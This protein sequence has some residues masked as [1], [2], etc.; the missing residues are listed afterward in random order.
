MAKDYKYLGIHFNNR[1]KCKNTEAVRQ[2][3]QTY[4]PDIRNNPQK[5]GCIWPWMISFYIFNEMHCCL[6][7]GETSFPVKISEKLK[8]LIHAAATPLFGL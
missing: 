7:C 3:C 1:W 6:F 8:V 5:K 4:D 2:W